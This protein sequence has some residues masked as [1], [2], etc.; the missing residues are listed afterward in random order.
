MRLRVQ[1][2]I[3]RVPLLYRNAF[4]SFLKEALK[5]TPSG[6]HRFFRLFHFDQKR[7]NKAPKPFCFAVRFVHDLK[8]FQENKEW[9]VLKSPLSLYFSTVDPSLLVDFYNGVI[10]KQIY[11]FEK[12]EFSIPYPEVVVP[13][14]EKR[15]TGNTVM[16]RTL[17]PVLI[18]D[19]QGKP[20][21]P[22]R[23]GERFAREFNYYADALLWGI[24][25][26]GL[27][28]KLVFQP[29]RIK[30]EVVKHAIREREET[31]RIYTFT[32]FSGQFVLRG[33]PADLEYIQALGI[34]RRRSQGFGMLEVVWVE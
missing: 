27:R 31:S 22:D 33:N 34:G 23:D 9:F 10:S 18:E 29:F 1:F 16:F 25:G 28:E 17:S 6:S 15:I 11:P 30:K 2:A 4:M 20:L 32:C 3:E 5:A 8:S 7:S 24:R 12:G 19:A 21:L 13:L 14:R 26:N